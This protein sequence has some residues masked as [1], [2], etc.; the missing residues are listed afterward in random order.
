LTSFLPNVVGADIPVPFKPKRKTHD[1]KCQ[2]GGKS[3]H[4][5]CPSRGKGGAVRKGGKH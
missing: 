5:T 2:K 3:I 4:E 1:R